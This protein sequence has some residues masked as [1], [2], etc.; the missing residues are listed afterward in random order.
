M[1]RFMKRLMVAVIAL[2]MALTVITPAFTAQAAKT[3]TLEDLG[4]PFSP[5]VVCSAKGSKVKCRKTY[6]G[7][8]A[9]GNYEMYLQKKIRTF[10]V[11]KST[12]YYCYVDNI[13]HYKLKKSTKS[14]FQRYCKKHS[15]KKLYSNSTLIFIKKKGSKIT[16]LVY[17]QQDWD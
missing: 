14:K 16:K 3:Y 4:I 12:K 2:A 7:E 8:D 15:S 5:Y 1:K 9:W 6:D 10:R 11:T 17:G 13:S